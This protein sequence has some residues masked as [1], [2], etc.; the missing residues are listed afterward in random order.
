[1]LVIGAGPIGLLAVEVLREKGARV[2]CAD[3]DPERLAMAS[4]VGAE[5]IE[6]RSEDTVTRVREATDGLGAAVTL[7]AVG[8]AATRAQAVAATRPAGLVL[9]SGLHAE[10][11]DFPASDVIRR[12]I[13]VR[14]TFCYTAEDFA[15]AIRAVAGGRLTLYPWVIEAPLGNGGAWFDRLVKAPGD[16]SKVLLVPGGGQ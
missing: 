16:V 2:F 8:T 10:A 5:A 15:E 1:V 3:L 13:V 12:E 4:D 7:D 14:G 9:L 6:P 11:S